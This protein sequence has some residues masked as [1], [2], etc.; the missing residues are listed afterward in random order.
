MLQNYV[1]VNGHLIVTDTIP[2]LDLLQSN[3]ALE[4]EGGVNGQQVAL[5]EVDM[6]AE[7]TVN[8]CINGADQE[9]NSGQEIEGL[10]ANTTTTTTTSAS[11]TTTT[12]TTTTEIQVEEV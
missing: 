2:N 7:E 10:A 5:E 12:T 3:V 1:L 6:G 9:T 11:T 8:D 4:V